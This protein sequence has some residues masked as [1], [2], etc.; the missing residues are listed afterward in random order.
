MANAIDELASI[1]LPPDSPYGTEVDWKLIEKEV[2]LTFPSDYREL[3][4]R[5]GSFEFGNTISVMHPR[6][7]SGSFATQ[8]A[9]L[10]VDVIDGVEG[11]RDNLEYENYPSIPGLFPVIYTDNN[12]L[13]CWITEGK[14]DDWPLIYWSTWG[15]VV[16]SFDQSITEFLVGLLNLTSPLVPDEFA[17]NWLALDAPERRARAVRPDTDVLQ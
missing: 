17:A 7:S 8:M 1:L 4:K 9:E 15:T 3:C 13:V 12:Q 2:G 6:Q 16:Q 14:P 11:G 5:Y 10:L